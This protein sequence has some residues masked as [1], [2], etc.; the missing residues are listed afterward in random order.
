MNSEGHL[1]FSAGPFGW[2]PSSTTRST[3]PGCEEMHASAAAPP[4]MLPPT[5]ETL[6]APFFGDS[7]LPPAHPSGAAHPSAQN[8]L[9][10]AT[11]R[12]LGSPAPALE[13]LPPLVFQ[14]A[15]S[16]PLC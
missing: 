15:S 9:D 2:P 16:N 12:S 6:F 7:A 11:C 5:T 3:S 4:P 8:R 1:S 13:I 10:H 14:P